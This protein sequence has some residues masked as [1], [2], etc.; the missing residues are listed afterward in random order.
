MG[1]SDRA[2]PA[3]AVRA[4]ACGAGGQPVPGRGTDA[5][6]HGRVVAALVYRRRGHLINVFVWP[7]SPAATST[8]SRDGYN[9]EKWS[10]DG[11]TFW[12]VSDTAAED[13]TRLREAFVE[14]SGK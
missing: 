10:K 11:L 9:I 1:Q 8:S 2:D 6:P 3:M 4:V 5:D 13:L 14:Q 7:A 12:A